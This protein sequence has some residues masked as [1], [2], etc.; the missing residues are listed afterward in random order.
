MINYLNG[1]P[2]LFNK[3]YTVEQKGLTPEDFAEYEKAAR[4]KMPQIKPEERRRNFRE[5]NLGLKEPEA[6]AEA[7]RCLECGC[8]DYFECKLIAYA[9][10]Y[11]VKPE[12]I[13]GA[14][15][16]EKFQEVHPFIERNSEK[17]IL[18]GL[19]VRVCDEVMGVTALGLV[20]RGFESIV[21]P[22]FNMALQDTD[23]IGCGQCVALCPTGAL[24]ERL[25]VKKNVPLVMSPAP[26]VCSF[27]S[28]GCGQVMNTCGDVVMRALPRPGEVLCRKGRFAFEA[29]NYERLVQP[30]VRRNGLLIE[31]TWEQAL[32]QIGQSILSLRARNEGSCLGMFISPAYSLQEAGAAIELG[33]KGLK[34]ENLSSFTPNTASALARVWDGQHLTGHFDELLAANVILMVGSLN[35]SPTA[36][37]KIRRAVA[38]GAQLIIVANEPTLVDNIAAIKVEPDNIDFLQQIE[39]GLLKQ[40]LIPEPVKTRIKG[41]AEIEAELA[42]MEPSAEAQNIAGIYGKARKAMIVADSNTVSTAAVEVLANLVLLNGRADSV[43]NGIIVV[44]PGSNQAGLWQMGAKV[45][46]AAMIN[47]VKEGKLAG[48]FIMGEDR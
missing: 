40:D 44:T 22:E 19:C 20:H 3:A 15:R 16:E 11:E 24:M 2:V 38:E 5:V 39:A 9:N 33:L 8:R 37:V 13:E 12:R 42:S 28:V 21:Q 32:K 14:K 46:A 10:Q 43:R 26:S 36:A 34:T 30:L 47:S 48:I 6:V 7:N 4:V 23:C 29:Y 18:C 1:K 41:F 17:C 45:E 31:T 35:E 25:P 27:C